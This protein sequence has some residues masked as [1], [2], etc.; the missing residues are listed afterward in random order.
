MAGHDVRLE[1]TQKLVFGT[2]LQQAVAILQLSAH[3]LANYLAEQLI[4]N[5]LLDLGEEEGEKENVGEEIATPADG[6]SA[7]YL[8]DYFKEANEPVAGEDAEPAAAASVFDP[9]NSGPTLY[10]HLLSQLKFLNLSPYDCLIAEYVIGNIGSDGY[11]RVSMHEVARSLGVSAAVV[12]RVLKVVQTLD[13]PGIGARDLRECLYL[14]ARSA[15]LGAGL[16]GRIVADYLE[17]VAAGKTGKIARELGVGVEEIHEAVQ[18]IRRFNPRPGSGFVGEPIQYLVPDVVVE[19]VGEEYVVTVNESAYPRLTINRAYR[20]LVGRADASPETRD[21]IQTRLKQALWVIKSIEQRRT[22]LHRIVTAL[23]QKQRG[24]LEAGIPA[25]RP[26]TMKEIA[27]AV[28][29]HES[30][31]SRATAQKYVQCP[32]GIFKLKFFFTGGVNDKNG[33]PVA[34]QSVKWL[35][36][37][38]VASEHPEKPLSDREITCIL[39]NRGIKVSRRTVAKYRADL[40]IP[41]T[42]KRRGVPDV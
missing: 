31:V 32:R 21:F 10:E 39:K 20:D 19:K 16:V 35:I 1:Q 25:L 18:I 22:T 2:D 23:V 11:F 9:A 15:G 26:L 36:K 33:T 6:E 42:P 17:A 4:E 24:F 40:N 41:G 8:G 38:I 12:E 5:P 7:D 13:P 37:E 34:A 29:L 28:G 3:E 30:T 14:Q 27:R